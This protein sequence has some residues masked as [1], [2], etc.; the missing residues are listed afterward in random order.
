MGTDEPFTTRGLKIPPR[1]PVPGEK[2]FEFLRGHDRFL[3]ELRN[4]WQWGVEAHFYQN[5]YFIHSRRFDTR[6]LAIQRAELEREAI[7]KDGGLMALITK[8]TV[9]I[10]GAGELIG[11]VLAREAICVFEDPQRGHPRDDA[12]TADG[13]VEHSH[14]AQAARIMNALL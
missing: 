8:R 7:M 6:H 5:G 13:A 10:L 3:C 9:L 14:A 4:H 12:T 2:L 11:S 1:Q